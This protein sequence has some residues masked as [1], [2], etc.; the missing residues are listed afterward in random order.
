LNI[1][2]DHLHGMRPP[3]IDSIDGT[4]GSVF[5]LYRMTLGAHL[6]FGARSGAHGR[7]G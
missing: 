2:A 6:E 3:R 5:A 4:R 1:K 7:R